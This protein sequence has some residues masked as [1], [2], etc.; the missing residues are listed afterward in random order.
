M[1]IILNTLFVINI[2]F[3]PVYSQVRTDKLHSEK[4]KKLSGK[5]SSI[6]KDYYFIDLGWDDG[7][8]AGMILKAFDRNGNFVDNLEVKEVIGY[9]VCITVLSEKDKRLRKRENRKE[10]ETGYS[11]ELEAERSDF[12]T[13]EEKEIQLRRLKDDN[14]QVRVNAMD[15]LS[16]TGGIDVIPEIIG[17]LNEKWDSRISG[18]SD[19][20]QNSIKNLRRSAAWALGE[21]SFRAF[22][23]IFLESENEITLD[24]GK[25]E[26]LDRVVRKLVSLCSD[27]DSNVRV[28][29]ARNVSRLIAIRQIFGLENDFLLDAL[30]KML[31]KENDDY[32]KRAIIEALAELQDERAIIVL[33][34]AWDNKD[35]AVKMDIN[36]ALEKIG[37]PVVP[38]MEE[39]LD[40]ADEEKKAN[41][42]QVL[43]KLGY[44]VKKNMGKYEIIK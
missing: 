19:S 42:I 24:K 6:E 32:A 25:E 34:A 44:Q 13:N 31:M 38:Y 23:Q 21:V 14:L 39:I 5:V 1:S 10:I 9:N 33:M 27:M 28:D 18:K 30:S 7:I 36:W 29:A 41:A 8:T 16:K 11:V 35:S 3:L 26:L 22:S 37:L 20:E 40:G 43:Y 4:I 12:A 15:I 2:I 17:V